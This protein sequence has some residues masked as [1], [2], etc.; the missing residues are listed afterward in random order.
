MLDIAKIRSDFPILAQTVHGKKLVYLDNAATTQLPSCVVEKYAAHY[1]SNNANVHR[2]IHTLSERSSAG[3]EKARD[4]VT[5]FL[6]AASPEEIVF[7]AG[8]TVGINMVCAGFAHLLQPGDEIITTQM[9]H[10]AN[11]VP[12]QQLCRRRGLTFRILPCPGGEPD[13]NALKN[14]LTGRTRLVAFCHVSNLTGTAMPIRDILDICQKHGNILT[15]IDGAQAVRHEPVDVGALGCD[16]YCFSGHKIMAPGGIGVLYGKRS[17]LEALRPVFFGG[18]IVDTVSDLNSSFAPLPHRLEA[19]TPNFQAAIGL[20]AAI[21]YLEDIGR[22][23][24]SS[25]EQELVH[26]AEKRLRSAD[27]VRVLGSPKRRSGA[28]PFIVEGVHSFDMASALDKL[29]IAVRSGHHCAQPALR[30]LGESH[31]LRVSP[32]FY[33]SFEEIDDLISGIEKSANFFRR[34]VT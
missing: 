21:A 26:Y 25:Y 9:E 2:G 18:G 32:A 11:F 1:Y 4:A 14:M 12:W 27:G 10:H 3:L 23:A 15:L 19:G 28:V 8:T 22:P 13:L 5:G 20:R 33:N 17:A 6:G 30:A 7:T 29:G 31:C 34:W 24:V 16:Y